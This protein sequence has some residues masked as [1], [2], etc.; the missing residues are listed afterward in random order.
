MGDEVASEAID[1]RWRV[2]SVE[3]FDAAM[4]ARGT[5]EATTHGVVTRIKPMA[6]RIR[7]CWKRRELC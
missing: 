7:F 2:N 4:A 3:G 5:N 6:G 1:V